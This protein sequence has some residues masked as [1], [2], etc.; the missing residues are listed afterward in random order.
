MILKPDEICVFDTTQFIKYKTYTLL[1]TNIIG[2]EN[3]E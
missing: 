2:N 1:N 3:D